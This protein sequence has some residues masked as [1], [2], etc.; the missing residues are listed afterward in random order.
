MEGENCAM[1]ITFSGHGEP[2]NQP[3]ASN[4]SVQGRYLV[5][6]LVASKFLVETTS[7]QQLRIF[8]VVG[9]V[10]CVFRVCILHDRNRSGNSRR[11]IT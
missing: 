7:G 3:S 10:G 6:V 4:P 8:L 1:A 2:L 9:C 5:A 11:F